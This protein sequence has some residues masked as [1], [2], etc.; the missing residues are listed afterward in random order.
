[1]TDEKVAANRRNALKSTGPKTMA[2]KRRASLN[3]LKHGLRATCLAI[4]GLEHQRDWDAHRA[5][6]V[7][8]LAPVGYLETMLA[9]RAASLLWR[10][11]RVA[12]YESDV[13]SIAAEKAAE[14]REEG[15]DLLSETRVK[16][17]IDL[18]NSLRDAEKNMNTVARVFALEP[19]AKLSAQDATSALSVVAAS[20]DVNLAYEDA[21]LDIPGLPG[22]MYWEDFDGWTREIVEAGVQRIKDYA[23]V[24]HA[25]LD[26]WRQ[27]MTA[28]VSAVSEAKEEF[29][30][31]TIEVDRDRREALLAPRETV[32]KISRYETTLERSLYRTLHELQK[33]QTNRARL[34]SGIVS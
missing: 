32:E 8:H 14:S 31:R 20:L 18:Q 10:L 1:M 24:E 5:Q 11:G 2:G 22:N 25:G 15:G 19:T 13:V 27:A 6:T 34:L 33:L 9:E 21:N 28:A 26:P 30:K 4:P 16:G 29:E 12:R 7:L 23:K 17:L 3:A